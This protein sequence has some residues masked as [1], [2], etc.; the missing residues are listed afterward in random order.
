MFDADQEGSYQRI[1]L[2]NVVQRL[3]LTFGEEATMSLSNR[4]QGG[5][6][7]TLYLPLS[8]NHDCLTGGE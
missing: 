3:R 8:A 4:L 5:A 6:S 7:V 2:I 1:G